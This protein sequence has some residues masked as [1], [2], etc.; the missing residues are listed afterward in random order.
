MF[1]YLFSDYP[2]EKDLHITGMMVGLMKTEPCRKDD[3]TFLHGN[4]IL[5]L[6]EKDF[7]S[8][9][10]QQELLDTFDGAKVEYVKNGHFATVLESKKYCAAI[11]NLYASNVDHIIQ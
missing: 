4:V 6:P 5:L 11:R 10:E 3:F 7:F 9:Y 1:D 8:P 2:K